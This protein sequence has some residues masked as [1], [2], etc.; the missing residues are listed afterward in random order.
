MNARAELIYAIDKRQIILCAQ[1]YVLS[2]YTYD[3]DKVIHLPMYYTAEMYDKFL[4]DLDFDYDEGYGAQRLM[5]TIWL[6]NGDWI[7]R[8]EY[9]GSE[10][11]QY[12][13][14]PEIPD[15]LKSTE[16]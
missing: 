1:I 13:T 16:L 10:W 14:C 4:V 7:E 2:E 8:G 9:D 15:Y 11:W 3:F 5:G 6:V 12:K